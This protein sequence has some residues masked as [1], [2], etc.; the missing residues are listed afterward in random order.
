VALLFYAAPRG[1]VAFPASAAQLNVR[2]LG[3][4]TMKQLLA[5]AL[6]LLSL[7][8]LASDAEM[9]KA[10]RIAR[11]L[12]IEAQLGE[13][14][15]ANAEAIKVQMQIVLQEFRRSGA[16]EELL[17]TLEELGNQMMGR[18]NLAW[19]PKEASRIYT[20]GLV[21]VLSD[22]ELD[23]AE[24]YFSSPEGKRANSAVSR[25]YAKMMEYINNRYNTVAQEE[26]GG[27]MKQARKALAKQ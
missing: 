1:Q 6:L 26:F 12:D 15:Q 10:E 7:S 9:R 11:V 19:D 17:G 22:S 14:Q 24:K 8:A 4:H 23:E 16:K 2:P 25:S 27:F 20:Q 3:Y 13:V 5:F 21:D 18:I